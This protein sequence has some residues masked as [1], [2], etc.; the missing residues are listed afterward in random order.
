M[1]IRVRK[2]IYLIVEPNGHDF[3]VFIQS[4][5]FGT[6]LFHDYDLSLRHLLDRTIIQYDG[7]TKF[8]PSLLMIK[9][10]LKARQSVSYY[11][12]SQ[13]TFSY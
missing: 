3:F 10:K 2:Y 6:T 7:K 13:L 1:R 9:T 4:A 8:R 5:Q 11:N 12:L